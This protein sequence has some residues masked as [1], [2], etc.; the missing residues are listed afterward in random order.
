MQN[1]QSFQELNAF[2]ADTYQGRRV[3]VL[4]FCYPVDI[5]AIAAAVGAFTQ[6]TQKINGNADFIL[7]DLN[8]NYGSPQNLSIQINDASTQENL[9]NTPAGLATVTTQVLVSAPNSGIGMY[10]RL[11]A[12]SNQVI[13]VTSLNAAGSTAFVLNLNGVQVFTY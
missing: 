12:N 5:A 8:L 2:I 6:S 1:L 13:T 9:F 11:A 3:K 10:R 4:P 7:C